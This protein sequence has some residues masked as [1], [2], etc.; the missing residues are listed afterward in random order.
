MPSPTYHRID[1]GAEHGHQPQFSLGS[2][3]FQQ[4]GYLM[5]RE[6]EA[7][8]PKLSWSDAPEGTRSFVLVMEEA[9]SFEPQPT[10]WL[11]YDIPTWTRSLPEGCPR[12]GIGGL[13]DF[14]H[15]GYEAPFAVDEEERRYRFVLRAVAVDSLD[16]PAGA[17]RAEV[18]AA[19]APHLLGRVELAA[20]Y[21][22]HDRD[23]ALAR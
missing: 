21:K 9:D 13:N 3:F 23:A 11:L 4:D 20:R 19:L 17:A 5:T 10:H 22:R 2:L 16:L 8:S 1:A 6:G 15:Q 14:G 7:L 12:V 18:E